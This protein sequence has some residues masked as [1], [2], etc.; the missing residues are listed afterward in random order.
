MK[1]DNTIDELV[2]ESNKYLSKN[3]KE[4]LFI[5]NWVPLEEDIQT[6]VFKSK[7]ARS[8]NEYSYLYSIDD[9][10]YKKYFNEFYREAYKDKPPSF[11]LYSNTTIALYLVFK[12]LA[13]SNIKNIVAFSPCYFTSDN[14]L[15]SLNF[16]IFYYSFINTKDF[17]YDKLLYIIKTQNIHGIL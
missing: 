7:I 16:N 17:N 13:L 12:K 11:S 10:G 1:Y 8:I 5:S 14:A 15:Q 4:P 6:V 3:Q 9:F 2:I